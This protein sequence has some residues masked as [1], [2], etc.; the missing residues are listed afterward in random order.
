M[1]EPE[2]SDSVAFK[3]R[4]TQGFLFCDIF[5]MSGYQFEHKLKWN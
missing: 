5:G 3:G 4:V 2:L 1:A